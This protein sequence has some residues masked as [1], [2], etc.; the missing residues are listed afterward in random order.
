MEPQAAPQPPHDGQALQYIEPA[1][2]RYVDDGMLS[3]MV[4][5]VAHRGDIVHLEAVGYQDRE[6][7][8]PMPT[9]AVFRLASMTK[10]IVST[11]VLMLHDEGR[12]EL[13]DPVSEYL[14]AFAEVVA[15]AGGTAASGVQLEALTRP[16][17]IRDLLTH[18]SGIASSMFGNTP[19]NAQYRDVRP[20]R[21]ESLE[22]VVGKLT[23]LP[24]QHQPGAAWTYG[25][26]TDVLAHLIEVVTGHDLRHVLQTRIFEPLG[27][28][29]TDYI[30]EA[31]AIDRFTTLY[32]HDAEGT[33]Q[34][35]RGPAESGFAE[36]PAYFRGNAGLVST[37]LDYVR[38]AQMILNDGALNGVRILQA[39]TAKQMRANHLTP[40]QLPMQLGPINFAGQGF[41]LGFGVVMDPEAAGLPF[42]EG[43]VWWVGSTDTYFWID[44]AND[45]VGILMTQLADMEVHPFYPEFAQ[46]V[47]AALDQE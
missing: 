44:P 18:S 32:T 26:S 30:V 9:D 34:R 3:G 25:L 37:A 21:S 1:M 39:E 41:G 27:M 31:D 16:V 38:F 35:L 43:T 45:V 5:L 7:Q 29:D 12:F 4:T 11:V 13:D 24:L 28:V 6:A 19:V 17:T 33:L 46:L 36:R 10:P 15:F 40:S 22:E 2:Q 42:G 14:P 23:G 47:Y 20:L 8:T